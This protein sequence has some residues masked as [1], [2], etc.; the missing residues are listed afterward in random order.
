MPATPRLVTSQWLFN[1]LQTLGGL[2]LIDS[3][4]AQC[5]EHAHVWS[6]LSLPPPP[7]AGRGLFLEDDGS[8]GWSAV[9][10]STLAPATDAGRQRWAKRKLTDVI[11][12]DAFGVYTPR[13]W[14]MT[15][16]NWLLQERLVTSVKLLQGGMQSFQRLY[17][18]MMASRKD[19]G[20][21]SPTPVRST[22]LFSPSSPSPTAKTKTH[23]LTFPHEIVQGSIYLGNIWQATHPEVLRKMGITHVVSIATAPLDEKFQLKGIK[24]HQVPMRSVMA[25]PDATVAFVRDA[26]EKG[27]KVLVH[28]LH[29][30][31][32]SAAVVVYYV[33]QTHSKLSLVTAYNHVHRC[34]NLIYP[35]IAYM[36]WL[37]EA[38]V[39][40]YGASSVES[41]SEIDDLQN[42]LLPDTPIDS[43]R[44]LSVQLSMLFRRRCTE[45]HVAS[46]MQ[47]IFGE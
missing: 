16:A 38:E 12:Y 2:T 17:P 35:N 21:E 33:M 1:R 24:Y 32:A 20:S 27:G 6:F 28:C 10:M 25:A 47:R 31:S 37:V 7:H 18:F 11:I 42:G 4:S 30:I 9:D 13:S 46:H 39:A 8:D 36:R 40:R 5:Y 43:T 44:K 41:L 26:T 22:V 19:N 34:R 14:A 3:R 23:A 45:K 29:G 15:L